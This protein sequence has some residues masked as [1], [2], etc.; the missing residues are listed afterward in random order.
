MFERQRGPRRA[1]QLGR[2]VLV[3]S[4]ELGRHRVV[5]Y[6]A[7][8]QFLAVHTRIGG[9]LNGEGD[10]L[11]GLLF[12]RLIDLMPAREALACSVGAGGRGGDG[13]WR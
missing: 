6:D 7:D 12:G 9:A 1:R 3:S 2:P 5:I 13:R 8:E 10:L 4:V 11:T